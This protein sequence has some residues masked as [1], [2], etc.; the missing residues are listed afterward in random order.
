MVYTDIFLWLK[1][2]TFWCSFVFILSE[3]VKRRRWSVHVPLELRRYSDLSWHIKGPQNSIYRLNAE[4]LYHTKSDLL[5]LVCRHVVSFLFAP[6]C[7]F[8]YIRTWCVAWKHHGLLDVATVTKGDRSLQ[9][10]N[11]E[12]TSHS[13]ENNSKNVSIGYLA[14][15]SCLS[16]NLTVMR[17]S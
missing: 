5:C 16:L 17:K 8:H 7:I 6:R 13:S 10:V 2:V 3:L 12:W 15:L 9:R 11:F 4:A 1:Q 14:I